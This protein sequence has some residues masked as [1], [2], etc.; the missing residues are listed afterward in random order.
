MSIC[1]YFPRARIASAGLHRGAGALPTARA[2][3][4]F[5]CLPFFFKERAKE[6]VPAAIRPLQHAQIC[7]ADKTAH[8]MPPLCKGRWRAQRGGGVV[9]TT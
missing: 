5:I 8:L 6:I 2:K 4:N 1:C 7:P 3:I 9:G